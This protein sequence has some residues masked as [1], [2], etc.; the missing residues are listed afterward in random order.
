MSTPEE[1]KMA[2]DAIGFGTKPAREG[3]AKDEA[4]A[5]GHLTAALALTLAEAG[6]VPIEADPTNREEKST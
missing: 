5:K 2:M 1:H 6:L 4:T 3:E